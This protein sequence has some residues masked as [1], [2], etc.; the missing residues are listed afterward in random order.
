MLFIRS[1]PLFPFCPLSLPPPLGCPPRLPGKRGGPNLCPF[2]FFFFFCLSVRE[3]KAP[4]PPFPPHSC[5][6]H[7]RPSLP[8]LASPPPTTVR[9]VLFPTQTFFFFLQNSGRHIQEG[10]QSVAAVA[11]SPP[12]FFTPN[13]RLALRRGLPP[14]PLVPDPEDLRF[15][16]P[17]RGI[18]DD[19]VESLF[20]EEH[21]SGFPLSPQITL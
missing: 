11:V 19:I 9:R 6:F 17:N 13:F 21:R 14:P 1:I 7:R 2:L 20:C 18:G 5:R 8:P 3:F 12:F 15:S 16:A 4:P 10:P